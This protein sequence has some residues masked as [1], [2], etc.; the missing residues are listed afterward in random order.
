M[1]ENLKQA[2]KFLVFSIT[3]G[4]IQIGSFTLMNELLTIPY[5]PAYL[6]SLILSVLFNY[7]FNRKYTFKSSNNV[8]I[9]MLLVFGYYAVF[10]PLS[11]LWGEALTQVGW[12]EYIVLAGTMVINFI[13]EFLWQRF[14]VFRKKKTTLNNETDTQ[15]INN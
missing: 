5:W 4:I 9:S 11:T 12:N 3:A 2:L 1:N 6:T 15:Q 10:T 8:P 7:V 13:T 14:V